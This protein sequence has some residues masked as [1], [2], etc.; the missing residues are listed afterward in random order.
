MQSFTG[1]AYFVSQPCFY[2]HVHVFKLYRPV[3]ISGFYFMTNLIKAL[4]NFFYIVC[5]QNTG[6][7]K[8][9]SMSPGTQNILLSHTLIKGDRSSEGLNKFIRSFREAA[10]P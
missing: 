7:A 4:Q 1:I 2:I 8:H 9:L 3:K 5:R 10:T 6:V